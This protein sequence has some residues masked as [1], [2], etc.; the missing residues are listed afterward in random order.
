MTSLKEIREEKVHNRDIKVSTYKCKDN[1]IIVEGELI[2]NR[3]VDT[4]HYDGGKRPPGTVHHLIIRLLID[5]EFVIQDVEVEMPNTPHE[6]CPETQN[7]LDEIKGL[8]I[9]RGFTMKIK[10]MFS[11]G[12][13]CSHL[14]ELLISMAPAAVQGFFTSFS[15]EP[16]PDGMDKSMTLFLTDTCWVWRKDGPALKKLMDIGEI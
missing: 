6:E 7:S 14:S 5:N 16:I 1:G 3:V 10:D 4:H 8:K 2:D 13:G 11:N 9:M 15:T 12:Q